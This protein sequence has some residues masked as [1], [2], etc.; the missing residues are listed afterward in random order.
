[1][2]YVLIPL[3]NTALNVRAFAPSHDLADLRETQRDELAG[4]FVRTLQT[5]ELLL[6]PRWASLESHHRCERAARPASHFFATGFHVRYTTTT[7]AMAK[8][9]DQ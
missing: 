3:T 5:C 8:D 6:R 4:V 7:K 1:M 9:L 2:R